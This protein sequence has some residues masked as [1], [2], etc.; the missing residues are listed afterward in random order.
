M[1]TQNDCLILAVSNGG[2]AIAE[3][4]RAPLFQ[5]FFRGEIKPNQLG[6]GLGLHIASEIAKAHGGELTVTSNDAETAQRIR[7]N[8][9]P[10]IVVDLML[11]M[12][13]AA[14][15]GEFMAVGPT[16]ATLL[17]RSPTTLR[18]VLAAN[19]AGERQTG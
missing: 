10:P 1:E 9:A 8:G 11:G 17:S 16:L 5:P 18:E 6:L 15:A 2:A 3:D 12:Y 14:R 4:A 13:Q 7:A 19:D